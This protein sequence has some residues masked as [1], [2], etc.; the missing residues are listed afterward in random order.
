MN[1]V[2]LSQKYLGVLKEINS[3]TSNG[4]PMEVYLRFVAYS[5]A[6][7]ISDPELPQFVLMPVIYD[8]IISEKLLSYVIIYGEPNDGIRHGVG[9]SG[10]FNEGTPEERTALVKAIRSQ[11]VLTFNDAQNNPDTR[12]MHE[13]ARQKGINSIAVIPIV[14]SQQKEKNGNGRKKRQTQVLGSKVVSLIV[15]DKVKSQLSFN[16]EEEE[17]LRRVQAIVNA[18]LDLEGVMKN[19]LLQ[20]SKEDMGKAGVGLLD[21]FG[22]PFMVIGWNSGRIQEKLQRV[23]ENLEWVESMTNALGSHGFGR[24]QQSITE[25]IKAEISGLAAVVA[26]TNT[27]LEIIKT[28]IQRLET[29]K[30]QL[31][32][33]SAYLMKQEEPSWEKLCEYLPILDQSAKV[34]VGRKNL[35]Q[36]FSLDNVFVLLPPE[37][38]IYCLKLI[39]KHVAKSGKNHPTVDIFHVE[40]EKEFP[41]EL[42]SIKIVV[43]STGFQPEKNILDD[44]VARITH[45]VHLTDVA[46]QVKEDKIVITIPKRLIN[47]SRECRLNV[48]R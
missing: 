1:A 33:Y 30:S 48:C 12:Y 44:Q 24:W 32:E 34:F 3:G 38:F 42:G 6:K 26:S 15:I 10:R 31:G 2:S 35:P 21:R 9:E 22:Q 16:A 37:R 23:L 14:A 17:F 20:I 36:E 39:M 45:M 13:L 18:S 19:S 25:E 7:L 27:N 4:L 46:I 29:E 8:D 47:I 41:G 40:D 43:R 28:H 11:E 5:V